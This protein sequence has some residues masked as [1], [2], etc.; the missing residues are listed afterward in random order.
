MRAALVVG[1]L[2]VVSGCVSGAP[3]SPGAGSGGPS[4]PAADNSTLEGVLLNSPHLKV[5][6]AAT[7]SWELSNATTTDPVSQATLVKFTDTFKSSSVGVS[8]G[9]KLVAAF[10]IDTLGS[11]PACAAMP[12]NVKSY[13]EPRDTVQKGITNLTGDFGPGWYHFVLVAVDDGT[14]SISFDTKKEVKARTLP[15]RDPY[16]SADFA[17]VSGSREPAHTFEKAGDAWLA[18]A[19]TSV[20]SSL[21][22]GGRE[23]NVDIGGCQSGKSSGTSANRNAKTGANAIAMGGQSSTAVKGAYK[24]TLTQLAANSAT[25]DV[26]W[27]SVREPKVAEVAQPAGS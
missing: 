13:F 4:I 19:T 14:F 12:T 5:V 15:A 16:V 10:P 6:G 25:L 21:T 3:K 23:L 8:G 22:D 24:P 7:L 9:M 26:A 2:I 17:S 1:F 18:W 27:V 11:P 20:G